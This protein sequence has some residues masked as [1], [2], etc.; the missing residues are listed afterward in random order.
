MK[1]FHRRPSRRRRFLAAAVGVAALFSG[2][3]TSKT[4]TS[5]QG[6]ADAKPALFK[7]ALAVITPKPLPPHQIDLQTAR[8]QY[9]SQKYDAAE[10]YLKKTLLQ[11]ADE[12]AALKILPWAYFFQKRYDKAL[13]A[14]QR[15]LAVNPR[16]SGSLA[17]M[18]WCYMGLNNH[19][20]AL[21]KFSEARK[22]SKDPYEAQKGTAIVY[23]RQKNFAKALPL[24]EKI[25]HPREIESLMSFWI[26]AVKKNPETPIP[27]LAESREAPSIF[28][29]P[30]ERPRYRS[31]LWTLDQPRN[32]ALEEAWRYYR[33]KLYRRALR[34]FQNLPEPLSQSLD[35]QNGLAWSYLENKQVG[36]AERVFKKLSLTYPGFIGIVK[37][38][39]R[40]ENF[41]MRK[42]AFAKYYLDMK[43]VR[44]AWKKFQA[45]TE[46]YPDWA[47]PHAQLGLL[48][49]KNG[50]LKTAD[51]HIQKSLALDPVNEDGLRGLKE[52]R[53]IREPELYEADRAFKQGNYKEAASRYFYY[54]DGVRN[55]GLMT[56][57]LADAYNGLGWS[58]FH[59]GEYRTA[60]E[61]FKLSW[62]RKS[63][64]SDSIK[65]IGYCNFY[66]K[67]YRS[68]IFY[69]K[70]AQ[71]HLPEEGKISRLLD[72]SVM[73]SWNL[74]Q[75]RLYFERELKKDPRRA[76]L[77]TGLG[78]VHF[79]RNKPNLAVEYFL[80]S[81]ALDPGSVISEEF[82]NF[83]A[84][85]RFGW[86]IYNRLGWA[87]YHQGNFIK[88]S[89]MFRISLKRRPKNSIA[90]KGM[91]Y[92]FYQAKN[93]T[94]A[95]EYLKQTLAK[96]HKPAPV[97]ET[98]V[99]ASGEGSLTT[100]TTVRSKLA[101]AYFH[102]GNYAES[103][104]YYQDGLTVHPG[105]SDSYDGLGWAYL[106]LRRLTESR[107][108]FVMA[109]EL[110]PLNSWSHKGLRMVKQLLAIGSPRIKK[111]I[112][113]RQSV[114]KPHAEG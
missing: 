79:K 12:P 50:D 110:E 63:F 33:Q 85:Q 88:S 39:Q 95:I 7:K 87:Y 4:P 23:L 54:I 111:P 48:E 97:K 8:R 83:L 38:L 61:K 82:F 109:V 16:D 17:G 43:K 26:S 69:L 86:Q 62:K 10:F 18:A 1:L 98:I 6:E 100:Q 14:F 24:L 13:M 27:V 29:L 28:T 5:F 66:L 65:G 60:M 73:R 15:N 64:R 56:E 36:N 20:Q 81:I 21:K 68:A 58:L 59:K 108:A 40:S 99:N 93:Y 9:N 34:A 101:R 92:N 49:L 113:I 67:N 103:I 94:S 104:R 11:A 90:Q 53:K 45:L 72:W 70:K 25:Y 96:N 47:Y 55:P 42:A 102:T 77:Y 3:A 19:R 41:K 44:I 75:A 52:L 57:A 112:F 89:E 37:G 107:A 46:E 76:S 22:I 32:E 2:C 31:I 30:V 74:G 106:R 105:Q 71:D 114:E 51:A 78:W 91:G 35:A 84:D 80:K